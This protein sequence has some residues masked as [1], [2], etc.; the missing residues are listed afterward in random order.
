MGL[1]K[2]SVGSQD[3]LQT[4][5]W[6]HQHPGQKSP[7]RRIP[8]LAFGGKRNG[9]QHGDFSRA[10]LGWVNSRFA[11]GKANQSPLT[12]QGSFG[13]CRPI[14]SQVQTGRLILQPPRRHAERRHGAAVAWQP[15]GSLVAWRSGKTMF[16]PHLIIDG[17]HRQE[18]MRVAIN[19]EDRK[20]NT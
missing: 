9:T 18:T 6:F 12:I 15:R 7:L 2:V 17:L 13:S 16:R 14:S 5:G 10:C 4:A 3:S 20:W 1:Q 19:P 8:G 11:L